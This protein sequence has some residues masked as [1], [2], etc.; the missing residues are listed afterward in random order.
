M[1]K[2]TR[3]GTYHLASNANLY[4]PQRTNVFE[5]IV[6]FAQDEKLLK[7]GVFEDTA[8]D[9]DYIR[10]DDAQEFLRLAVKKTST[11][12]FSQQALEVKRGNSTMKFA[13]TPTFEPLTL[14]FDDFITADDKSAL[15]AW[16]RKSYD[17]TTESVGS[18]V[19][20]KRD[21]TLIEYTPDRVQVRYWNIHGAWISNLSDGGF[22]ASNDGLNT[23]TATL[24]YDYA[25]M[26]L[27]DEE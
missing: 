15:M 23:L 22:D 3:V 24:Q 11:P 8:T 12:N 1:N 2:A 19:D 18:A 17:V 13:G 27:P 20:Y 14:E 6:N 7:A 5:F 26:H 9:S 4:Q 16:Q 25:E 21:C 10:G